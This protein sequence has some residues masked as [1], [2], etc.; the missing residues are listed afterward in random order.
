MIRKSN[1]KSLGLGKKARAT[2][3]IRARRKFVNVLVVAGLLGFQPALY[4]AD[5]ESG[6]QIYSR[7][8]LN[9]HGNGGVPV[10]PGVPNFARGEGLFKPNSDL[11][12]TIREGRH[13]MPAY[14]GILS[15]D[16]ID[17]VIAYLRTLR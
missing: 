15:N 13:I 1:S 11:S 12:R 3:S 10:M 5:P 8:C 14:E 16:E 17:D 6:G 7:H 9:C 4:A 2:A